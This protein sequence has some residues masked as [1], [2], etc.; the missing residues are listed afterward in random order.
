MARK[1]LPSGHRK[2]SQGITKMV[3]MVSTPS[4]L[5]STVGCLVLRVRGTGR[6]GQ[7]IRLRSAKCTVGSGLNCTLRLRSDNVGPA[8]CLILRGPC[9]TL[10]RRWLPDT[11]L[12]GRNFTESVL[13]AGDCL[14][15]GGI[16]LEVVEIGQPGPG[17]EDSSDEHPVATEQFPP[18]EAGHLAVV[19]AEL[20]AQSRALDVKQ[21]A[22]EVQQAGAQRMLDDRIAG[23]DA[24]RVDLETQ[25][26]AVEKD[27]RAWEAKIAATETRPAEPVEAA[28]EMAASLPEPPATDSES[29]TGLVA[30]VETVKTTAPSTAAPVDLAAVLRQTGFQIDQA[31]EEPQSEKPGNGP[32]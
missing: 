11:R 10:V 6:D 21:A 26:F 29:E 18:Q 2:P 13:Q 22:W 9:R 7:I 8:H 24:L 5:S 12:N 16:D 14:S 1:S 31:D 15:V 23:L 30:E 20:D 25:R 3:R 19:Q 17:A 4:L 32:E 28:G 27:R